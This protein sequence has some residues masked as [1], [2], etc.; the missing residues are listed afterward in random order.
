MTSYKVKKMQNNSKNC[1][2]CGLENQLGLKAHFYELDDN[3]LAAIFHTQKGHQSYPQRLHGGIASA[4]L[5]E[6]LGRALNITEPEAWAVTVELTLRYHKPLPLDANIKALA[7]MDHNSRLLFEASG[8][9]Y[10]PD[11]QI[12]VTAKGKYM[13]MPLSK[14]SSDEQFLDEEWKLDQKQEIPEFI[15]I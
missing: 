8:E 3:Q 6:A 7:R 2:V 9:I 5:D 14:I 12:A 13:K 11:G 10:L 1:I 15:E 4:I